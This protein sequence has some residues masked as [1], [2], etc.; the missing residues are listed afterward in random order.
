MDLPRTGMETPYPE[1]HYRSIV[2][3]NLLPVAYAGSI[4]QVSPLFSGLYFVDSLFLVALYRT[5]QGRK[6]G[7]T[8]KKIK[9]L[10]LKDSHDYTV[11]SYQAYKN[12]YDQ[13]MKLPKD[14]SLEDFMKA[15]QNLEKYTDS[16]K[17]KDADYSQ[18]KDLISKIP[19]DLSSYNSDSV[20]NLNKVLGR[21][22]YNKTILEQSV[23]VSI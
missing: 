8:N 10:K 23:V 22:V 11:N 12:A 7:L 16:L 21:I 13:F 4:Q 6:T 2:T 20:A 19:S 3:P 14:V 5:V 15:K 18:I 1:S 9:D 17:Y